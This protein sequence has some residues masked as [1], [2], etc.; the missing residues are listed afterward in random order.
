MYSFEPS[1]EQKML[2]DAALKFAV[3]D[4]REAAHQA[5]EGGQLPRAL[6]DRG[7]ELG[8]LQAS[9]PEEYG[10]F[11]ERS[12]VTMAL[13]AEELAYGDLA[14]TLSILA[15]GLFALPVLLVG[16]EAQKQAYLP[17]FCTGGYLP[18]SAAL[19][20]LRHD[21]RPDVL[22][23]T[24]S[25]QDDRWVLNGEKGYVPLAAQAEYFLVYAALDG[26]TQGFIVQKDTPGLIIGAREQNMGI[27]AL[28]TY[29]L[30]LSNCEVPLADR[31]GGEGGHDFAP[32][33]DASRAALAAMAVGVSRGAYEYALKYA[34]EREA[35][36]EPVAHRQS[37]AFMLA[38]MA[39]E[40]EAT[41][42]MAWEAAWLLDQGR[43]ATR[44]AYLA[45]ITADDLVLMCT[46]RAVQIL[47]GHGYIRDHPVEMWLRNARGFPTF[48]GMAML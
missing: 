8:L 46:D 10:G 38:E 30:R 22:K 47:G 48:E 33:I 11:G 13:V 35:F 32:I 29:A 3:K 6:I 4:L 24:A 37:I 21:F 7:W 15:P 44:E 36:G 1:E 19:I 31:L 41:R 45:K 9:I 25:K 43:E 28:P 14:A 39:T 17:A 20:E 42:L 26:R 27:H 12:A 34:K 5:D 16:S 18:A 23:T 40:I 2:V